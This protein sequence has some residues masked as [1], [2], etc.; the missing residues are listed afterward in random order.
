M[1]RFKVFISSVQKE[2]PTEREA[3]FQH[4][5]TDALLSNYFE[6]V[7]FEKLP[8]ANQAPNKVY[9]DEV[10]Q[11]QIY[12][13]LLGA[14]YGFEDKKG[15]SPTEH[16]YNHATSLNLERWV[17]I[18]GD[19]DLKRHE[20]EH[21]FIRKVGEEVSRK[22]FYT[23]DELK[24]EVSKACVAFLQRK[25]LLAFT[26]FDASLHATA[27]INDIDEEKIQMFVRAARAK[28]AFPLNETASTGQV[29]AHLNM[30]KGKQITNSALLVFGKKPQQFF[31][32]AIVKCAHFHG[33]QVAKPIPDHKVFKGDVFEQVDQAVDFVLSKINVSV[34]TRAKS[35]QAPVLYEIPRA[36]VTEA[37]VNAI[38]HRDYTS[39]GSV[40][41]MLFSD[42]LEISNPGSLAPELSL[43][44][45]RT[46]HASYPTNPLLA[47]C[48]YETGYIE[49]FGTGT[50]EIIRLSEE[51]HLNDPDFKIDEGFKVILWRPPV[52]IGQVP[53][54]YRAGT[55]Q[56]PGSKVKGHRAGTGQV[57][58]KYRASREADRVVLVLDGEMKRI[59]IQE[60]LQLKHRDSFV[61]NYLQPAMEKKFVEM[62][63]PDKPNSSRQRY[64]LT[65]KGE[66]LKKK[67]TKK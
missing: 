38:A 29:L 48:M 14:E 13:G 66:A 23:T 18:K 17:F 8:A 16:E 43:E 67:L 52:A 7:V 28:R 1:R 4:L 59:E 40:Q 27:T 62:T 19:A 5:K 25:G 31:P 12:L 46:Q 15:I 35:V 34:G 45:L 30:L 53:G 11:S 58:G 20:K 50:L 33:K 49:R 61:E 21:A 51:A 36:A 9:I 39:N 41:V 44:Q 65:A 6:P 24:Q 64:R 10:S 32:A 22:R 47:E 55:G 42:R 57:P 2:F 63:I 54:K 26:P 3:L 56:V 60:A 37:I